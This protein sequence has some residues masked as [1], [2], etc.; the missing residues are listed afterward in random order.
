MS[1]NTKF[2]NYNMQQRT[3]FGV[4]IPQVHNTSKPQVPVTTQEDDKDHI[5]LPHIY[6]GT[7]FYDE[8]DLIKYESHPMQ[9]IPTVSKPQGVFDIYKY[10]KKP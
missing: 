10:I 9:N 6:E 5:E 3:K 4:V 2:P 1:T 7:T 8:N